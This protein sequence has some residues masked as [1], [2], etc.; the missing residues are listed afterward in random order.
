MVQFENYE[1]CIPRLGGAQCQPPLH[2]TF[3]REV[4]IL[5]HA[6]NVCCVQYQYCGLYLCVVC[7]QYEYCVV[8]AMCV[9]RVYVCNVS[10]VYVMQCVWV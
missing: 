1:P 5:N 4:Q 3:I 10:I 2:L 7:V 6:Y 8:C 9:L